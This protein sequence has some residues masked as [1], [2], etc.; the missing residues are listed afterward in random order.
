MLHGAA[1]SC[2]QAGALGFSAALYLIIDIY[3]K[4]RIF[5][6]FSVEGDIY[7][8]CLGSNKSV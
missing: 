4:T 8:S 3:R 6:F 2:L 7:F 5:F 1:E